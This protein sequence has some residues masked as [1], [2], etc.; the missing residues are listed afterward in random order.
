M[1]RLGIFSATAHDKVS[2][3]FCTT[4]T[5]DS[6][7]HRVVT[8]LVVTWQCLV[9]EMIFWLSTGCYKVHLVVTRL[10][11]LVTWLSFL[12]GLFS[13]GGVNTLHSNTSINKTTL[14]QANKNNKFRKSV[15]VQNSLLILEFSG[16]YLIVFVHT[17]KPMINFKCV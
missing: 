11:C 17:M 7:C 3:T 10:L 9:S 15:T 6:G 2:T 4:S 8:R 5:N 16:E 1:I 12:Y 13:F 14:M